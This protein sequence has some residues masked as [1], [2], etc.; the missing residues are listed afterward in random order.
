MTGPYHKTIEEKVDAL[1]ADEAKQ[2]PM[3]NSIVAAVRQMQA[4][5]AFRLALLNQ[6]REE[7][8]QGVNK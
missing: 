7:L 2:Q 4:K 1:I 6:I 5:S 8:N 3:L